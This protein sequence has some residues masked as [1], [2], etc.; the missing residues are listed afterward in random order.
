MR[1]VIGSIGVLVAVVL[2]VCVL[3]INTMHYDVVDFSIRDKDVAEVYET[4][5][6]KYMLGL[7]YDEDIYYISVDKETYD[8]YEFGDVM[9]ATSLRLNDGTF[10]HTKIENMRGADN[11]D[12]SKGNLSKTN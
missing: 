2:V 3:C 6:F 8:S 4:E 9:R 11:V 1:K 12:G 10:I 7:G 5:D